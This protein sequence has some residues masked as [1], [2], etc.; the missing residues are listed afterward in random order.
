MRWLLT[1]LI[2]GQNFL[3]G[4]QPRQE[5][6]LINVQVNYEFNQSITIAG[7]LRSAQKVTKAGIIFQYENEQ[8]YQQEF[9]LQNES[10]ISLKLIPQQI[11]ALP[12]SRIYYWFVFS[13]IDGSQFTSPTYWFDYTDN[14]Y[15][16]KNSSSKWFEVYW[17]TD[18]PSFGEKIQSLGLDGLKSA[19]TLLPISPKLPIKIYVYPDS[20]SLQNA[21]DKSANESVSGTALL[22]SNTILISL[23][24]DLTNTAN[25]ERQI[26]HEITHLLEYQVSQSNYSSVPTWLIEGLATLSENYKDSNQGRVLS[27]AGQNNALLQIDQ[28]C[29]A[30]PTEPGQQTLAYAESAAFTQFLIQKFGQDKVAAI[31][32]VSGN[33][34]SCQQIV[35][36]VFAIDLGTLD[37]DWQRES[38]TQGQPSASWQDYWPIFILILALT[39]GLILIRNH[40]KISQRSGEEHDPNK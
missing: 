8:T 22:E 12:F 32:F 36:N 35:K 40:K 18:D 10:D 21:A 17:S 4:F 30:F 14:H 3:S 28:L 26:P 27:Q 24:D 29:S 19:T 39:L 15:E 38:L 34:L 33:G 16:W 6:G 25:L 20:I 11:N 31:L 13:L 5:V 23:S 37:S 7:S 1:F 2:L 9:S